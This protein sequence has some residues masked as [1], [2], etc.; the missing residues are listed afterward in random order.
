M[1]SSVSRK[2]TVPP[3]IGNMRKMLTVAKMMRGG[4]VVRGLQLAH[5]N[6]ES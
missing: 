3:K 5:T 4:P 2:V 1:I 6:Y